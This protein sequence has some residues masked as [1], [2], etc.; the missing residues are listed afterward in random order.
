MASARIQ[1]TDAHVAE[2]DVLGSDGL[3]DATGED[4]TPRTELG[5]KLS[6]LDV[7]GEEDGG[8]AVGLVV[9]VGGDLLEAEVGN[10]SLD[11]VRSRLVGREP[12]LDALGNNLG[13]GGVEGADELG[14]GS[15]K[16]RGLLS[17]VV[18]HD[19]SARNA[20]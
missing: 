3:V 2:T 4:N 19:C 6:T 8:H 10:G 20:C 9:G 1:H 16:V 15:S 13:K 18:L 7:L 17:L 14:R 5:K 11:L 12:F